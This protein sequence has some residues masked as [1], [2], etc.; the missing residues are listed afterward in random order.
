MKLIVFLATIVALV[1]V[2]VP[3]ARAGTVTINPSDD[4]ALYVLDGGVVVSK[5][6]YL[7]VSGYIQGAAKFPTD[8]ITGTVT[9]A[10]LTV[11]PYGLPLSGF[12]IDVY[13]IK[14]TTGLITESD[15]NA[16][17]F[18]GTWHIPQSLGYGQDAFFDVTDF[19]ASA[20]TPFVGF[21]LRDGPGE[22]DVFSSKWINYGHPE[23]LIVTTIPEPSTIALVAASLA[24]LGLARARKA[25][26]L[27]SR[28]SM[29]RAS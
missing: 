2:F 13:G 1:A 5:G 27:L 25:T 20:D 28:F 12:N 11:N 23:Q 9:Q 21:D 3:D 18:L 22:T 19:I 4:A 10:F 29:P 15:A 14:S 24:S 16:G 6:Q 7:L 8:Q 26:R 17:V